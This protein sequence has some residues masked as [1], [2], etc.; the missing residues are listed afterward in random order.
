MA[1]GPPG[2]DCN[3]TERTAVSRTRMVSQHRVL[4]NETER[5]A[6]SRTRMVSQYRVLTNE[7][8]RTAVS[9]TCIVLTPGADWWNWANSSQHNM[10]AVLTPGAACNE[11][12]RTAV[13]KLTAYRTSQI[14]KYSLHSQ[15]FWSLKYISQLPP[16]TDYTIIASPVQ[17]LVRSFLLN[18]R[19]SCT[20]CSVV[21]FGF[22]T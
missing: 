5:T 12:E 11:T 14:Y 7:T 19:H 18:I 13:S 20:E 4:T 8:E 3:E 1:K 16:A 10:A 21:L 15:T 9:R 6:V 17:G 2:A 22:R